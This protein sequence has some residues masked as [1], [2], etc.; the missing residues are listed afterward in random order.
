MFV[1]Q[2]GRLERGAGLVV[3][4]LARQRH[5][6][7]QR[8]AARAARQIDPAADRARALVQAADAE[9]ACLGEV[10]LRQAAAVVGDLERQRARRHRQVER[11]VRRVRVL[12][13]VGQR[14]L[15]GAVRDQRDAGRQRDRLA[16]AREAAGDAGA[17]LEAARHPLQRRDQPL[18]EDRRAQVVHH[19]LARLDRQRQRLER[20]GDALAHLGLVGMARDPG[21]VE[22]QRRQRPADVV[23]QVPLKEMK[24]KV[25]E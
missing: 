14:L 13:D 9:R 23:V 20:R 5:R 22:V 11:D 25:N 2:A 16:V 8:R 21:E 1:G 6:Q 18:L 19:A 12:G 7:D 3:G 10:V 24:G 17:A 4:R 15:R